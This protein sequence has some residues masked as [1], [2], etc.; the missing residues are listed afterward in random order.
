MGPIPTE[1][2]DEGE[3]KG[4]VFVPFK[5]KSARDDAVKLLSAERQHGVYAKE[6]LPNEKRAPRGLLLGL[7][8]LL[9]QWGY[10]NVRVDDGFTT[11][12]VGPVRVLTLA[13]NEMQLEYT[14]DPEWKI[15]SYFMDNAEVTEL[16]KK[17]QSTLSYSGKGLSK[18][19]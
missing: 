7:R 3:Y 11:L 14:W 16:I 10:K 19:K 5:A 15:W 4:I 18:G 13:V 6:D 2:F 9:K 8:W 12:D 17:A 1:V